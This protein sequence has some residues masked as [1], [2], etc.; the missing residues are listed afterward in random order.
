MSRTCSHE[1]HARGHGAPTRTQANSS[2]PG[3]TGL[4]H[5]V[6]VMRL[7]QLDFTDGPSHFIQHHRLDLRD[8]CVADGDERA[9]LFPEL[10]NVSALQIARKHHPWSLGQ[11][12]PLMYVTQRPVVVTVAQESVERTGSIAG[13]PGAAVERRVQQTKVEQ[14]RQWSR[15]ASTQVLLHVTHRVAL[16]MKGQAV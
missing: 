5:L 16:T 11:D 1:T 8:L 6:Q 14:P 4:E 7:V 15:V 10:T 3:L 2:K 12:L 13:V 9:A